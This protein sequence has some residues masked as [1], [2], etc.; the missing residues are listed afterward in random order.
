MPTRSIRWEPTSPR[1]LSSGRGASPDLLPDELREQYLWP[2]AAGLTCADLTP[3]GQCGAPGISGLSDA[4]LVAFG[5]AIPYAGEREA[6]NSGQYVA[7]HCAGPRRASA[8][9]LASSTSATTT[10]HL[11]WLH[12]AEQSEQPG[13]GQLFHQLRRRQ[14]S[15]R[16][17]H[18]HH[19]G[20]GSCCGELS[21][22]PDDSVGIDPTVP[23]GRAH[24]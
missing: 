21:Y 17:L 3:T 2:W 16:S 4:D 11:S 10:R 20:P 18:E 5:P 19:G 8:P 23:F 6:K 22:R 13:G 14:G 1:R 12:R 9:T 7:W 15:V 24:R